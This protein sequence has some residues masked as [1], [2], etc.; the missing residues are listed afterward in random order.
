VV[1]LKGQ[2]DSDATRKLAEAIARET[3]GV[4]RI[5]NHLTVGAGTA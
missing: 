3:N 5:V 1:T 4:R 2:V